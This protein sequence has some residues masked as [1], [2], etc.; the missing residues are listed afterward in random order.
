VV[1]AWA[2]VDGG[3]IPRAVG[4]SLPDSVVAS[5]PDSSVMLSLRLPAVKGL[6]FRHVLF[7]WV[8]GGHPP[9]DLYA[10]AHWDAHFYTISPE[11]RRRIGAG[12]ATQRPGPELMPEGVVPVPGLGLYSFPEMGVHWVHQDAPELVGEPFGHTLIYGSTGERPIFVEP[13]V[14]Q[15]RLAQRPDVTGP[16]AWPA[17]VT[18]SGF[19]P[20]AYVIRHE[21]GA[22][23]FRLSLE[24][25]RWR[26]GTGG[27]GG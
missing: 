6:P 26:E 24:G 16:V 5:V 25:F 20:T 27:P 19:Y 1:R 11:E 22:A 4:V 3:G 7:D 21:P 23:G 8:P 14:T 15:A 13:M 10:A 17:T 9:A 12:E 18:E 2:E